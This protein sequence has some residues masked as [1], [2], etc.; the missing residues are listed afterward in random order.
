M[1]VQASGIRKEPGFADVLPDMPATILIGPPVRHQASRQGQLGHYAYLIQSIGGTRELGCREE[2]VRVLQT[3]NCLLVR[4]AIA[5][6]ARG[7]RA[8]HA[9]DPRA[10]QQSTYERPTFHLASPMMRPCAHTKRIRFVAVQSSPEN[11]ILE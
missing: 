10:E 3:P 1:E 6:S 9:D 11:L 2:F 7:D 5:P 4:L 8:A